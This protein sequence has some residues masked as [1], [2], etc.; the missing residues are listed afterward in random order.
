MGILQNGILGPVI[1]KVGPVVGSTWKGRN[2]VRKYSIPANPNSTAQQAQ[3]GLFAAVVAFA[4]LILTSVIHPFWASVDS[5][6]G[7][8]AAFL[9]A[10]LNSMTGATSYDKLITGK[11]NLE[12]VLIDTATY[13]TGDVT[14]IWDGT[15]NGNGDANDTAFGVVYD[16]ANDVA[17]TGTGAVRS[18]ETLSVTVGTGRNASDLKA[19]LFFHR[20]EGENLLVSNSDYAQVS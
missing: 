13:A 2:T 8:Y 10:N 5:S 4:R 19:Y 17:F 6:I 9:S 11:G 18:E 1:G 14:I 12:S 16:V 7:A 15:V 3:R 20:T